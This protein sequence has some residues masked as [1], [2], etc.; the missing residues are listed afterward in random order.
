[1]TTLSF[2]VIPILIY[3]ISVAIGI[4]AVSRI[5]DAK[6]GLDLLLYSLVSICSWLVLVHFSDK[7][8]TLSNF[9]VEPLI[10]AVMVCVLVAI[11]FALEKRG[12]PT[13]KSLEVI[14]SLSS[15]LGTLCIYFLMPGLP[16]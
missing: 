10:L 15:F 7:G 4:F 3:G 12:I 2:F 6:F 16:E 8:K 13:G 14:T 9:V 11:H 1:M 5:M